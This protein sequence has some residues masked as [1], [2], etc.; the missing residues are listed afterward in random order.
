M[1]H[2]LYCHD[3]AD[4]A[5][6][7]AEM[8]TRL[9]HEV[10]ICT[11][12]RA[13]LNMIAMGLDDIETVIIHKDLGLDREPVDA[14]DVRRAIQ[15]QQ[16]VIRV[17]FISGEYPDGKKHVLALDADFYFPTNLAGNHTWLLKQVD[18]GYVSRAGLDRRGKEVTMP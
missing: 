7:R 9:G 13:S 16:E 17:G 15:E 10:T 4:L 8:L 12:A 18:A 2:I 5:D 3:D 11:S 1:S 14:S 6:T